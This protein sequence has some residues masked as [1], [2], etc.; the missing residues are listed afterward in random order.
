LIFILSLLILPRPTPFP[1]TTLFRSGNLRPGATADPV[2]LLFRHGDRP[3]HRSGGRRGQGAG[4]IRENG[5]TV[6]PRLP[7]DAPSGPSRLRGAGRG[8]PVR[9][10]DAV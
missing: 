9:Q 5:G 4:G 8:G 1:Y 7:A 3:L 10:C 6:L 2:C